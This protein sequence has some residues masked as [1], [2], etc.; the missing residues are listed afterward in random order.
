MNPEIKS[1]WVAALRN[2]KYE[3]TTTVL[4]SA[5][6]EFCCLGVLCDLVDGERWSEGVI[7]IR[8]PEGSR[9]CHQYGEAAVFPPHAIVVRASLD[10]DVAHQLASMNDK[11][12]TFSEIADY[13][14]AN[15]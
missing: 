12:A 1:K 11:G 4:R 9:F 14:E 8:L 5:E 2:G 7:T 15:L 3:Q 10:I 13:I 6:N